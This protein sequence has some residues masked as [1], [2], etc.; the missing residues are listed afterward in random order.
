MCSYSAEK[1]WGDGIRGLSMEAARLSLL[2]LEERPPHTKNWRPQ[3]LVLVRLDDNLIPT[4]PKLLAFA[5]QLK[6]GYVVKNKLLIFSF[7][8]F[9]F[10]RQRFDCGWFCC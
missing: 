1:E 5:S 2:K 3:L 7:Y 6:A 9:W 4:H 8:F 10:T